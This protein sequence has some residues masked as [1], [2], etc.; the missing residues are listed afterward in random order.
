MKK[1]KI[2][3]SAVIILVL[4]FIIGNVSIA[5]DK[6]FSGCCCTPACSYIC[7]GGEWMDC[8]S[9]QTGVCGFYYGYCDGIYLD[10]MIWGKCWED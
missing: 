1:N 6:V 3:P 9:G 2:I 5:K 7:I 8:G 10:C 4:I